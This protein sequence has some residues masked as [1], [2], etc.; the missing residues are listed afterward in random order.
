[1]KKKSS[2]IVLDKKGD[3]VDEM[4]VRYIA[5]KVINSSPKV[6]YGRLRQQFLNTLY[7]NDI[8]VIDEDVKI[9]MSDIFDEVIKKIRSSHEQVFRGQEESLGLILEDLQIMARE[10]FSEYPNYPDKVLLQTF[11]S[12]ADQNFKVD[13]YNEDIYSRLKEIFDKQK[14]RHR[15][16]M[17]LVDYGKLIFNMVK[18]ANMLDQRNMIKE[19]DMVDGIIR[20][21]AQTSIEEVR[22]K[23]KMFEELKRIKPVLKKEIEELKSMQ[24]GNAVESVAGDKRLS[25]MAQENIQQKSSRVMALLDK[26]KKILVMMGLVGIASS[27]TPQAVMANSDILDNV[28]QQIEWQLDRYVYEGIGGIFSP[29]EKKSSEQM[30]DEAMTPEIYSAVGRNYGNDQMVAEISKLMYE[31]GWSED[32]I[33]EFLIFTDDPENNFT[34]IA[35]YIYNVSEPMQKSWEV[36][37]KEGNK[38]YENYLRWLSS[39][40]DI[41]DHFKPMIRDQINKAEER[42]NTHEEIVKGFLEPNEGKIINAYNKYSE[43]MDYDAAIQ[44][45]GDQM[46]SRL[47]KYFGYDGRGGEKDRRA[48]Q[49]YKAWLT[50]WFSDWLGERVEFEFEP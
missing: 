29:K 6:G 41:L 24:Q 10:L 16:K 49:E 2:I 4:D 34:S 37:G 11:L 3:P 50:R 19:S 17:E 38:G 20:H 18:I 36:H 32:T 27:L 23:Q 47:R 28:E 48:E 14:G 43:T 35:R 15:Q 25:K 9:K 30:A 45:L 22:E 7:N 40:S 1:M 21:I 26:Y 33:I 42:K 12:K 31:K 13:I 46:W 39:R 5:D 8:D 44:R